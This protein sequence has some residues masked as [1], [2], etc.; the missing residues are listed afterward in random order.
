MG[1]AHNKK[2]IAR[3]P[4]LFASPG[5]PKLAAEGKTTYLAPTGPNT[6][7]PDLKGLKI[8]DV[9]DGTSNTIFLVDAADDHA[10]IW[11]KPDDLKVDPKEPLKGLGFKYGETV[12]TLFVDG[13]V[14][15]LK[16]TIDKDTLRG[17]FTPSG[18]EPIQ[19]P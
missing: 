5:N 17:L 18:G 13:S 6:M 1:Q 11:T 19:V 12:L 8:G 2:L 10:V 9:T 4:R 15:A 3:M 16:K 14:H 7:F